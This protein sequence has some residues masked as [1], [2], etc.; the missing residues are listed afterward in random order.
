MTTD[1]G[2]SPADSM[3]LTAQDILS[4]PLITPSHKLDADQ[5]MAEDIDGVTESVFGSGNMN[6]LMLQAGQTD[7]AIRSFGN[8]APVSTDVFSTFVSSESFSR[9]FPLLTD[10]D[11]G[12][13]GGA[14]KS[15]DTD[16]ALDS[17]GDI[18]TADILAP[19]SNTNNASINTA[20]V[21]TLSPSAPAASFSGGGFDG[22]NGTG[23]LPGQD[24]Q[25]P[26]A[27]PPGQNGTNGQNGQNGTNG[28]GHG[29][30]DIDINL[31]DITI[32][33]ENILI[34]LGDTVNVLTTSVTN[35]T[36]LLNNLLCHGNTIDITNVIDLVFDIKHGLLEKIETLLGDVGDKTV[37]IKHLLGDI[38]GDVKNTALDLDLN[39]LDTVTADVHLLLKDALNGQILV[40]GDLTAL[41]SL[42]ADLPALDHLADALGNAGGAVHALQDTLH[43]ALNTVTNLPDT[44]EA[45]VGTL[46]ETLTGLND[47]VCCLLPDLDDAVG[48]LLGGLGI[49]EGGADHDVALDVVTDVIGLPV[50]DVTLDA[51]LNP[52]EDIIGDLDL[53]L[54]GG[55][56][57]LGGS[58]T[59]HGAG[60]T[61]IVL[62]PDIDLIDTDILDGG[63][64]ISL[65][66]IEEITGDIDLDVTT[67]FDLLGDQADGLIDNALGGSE[68]DTPLSELGDTLSGLAATI[69]PDGNDDQDIH[70]DTGSALPDIAFIDTDLDLDIPLDPL[71][72]V[73]GDIDLDLND[74]LDILHSGAPDSPLGEVTEWTETTVGD[75]TGGLF[76][77]IL[78]GGGD[79]LPE[80]V[81]HI[82]EG[83]GALFVEP[84]IQ[85]IGLGRLFG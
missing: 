9:A 59:D 79:T 41:K 46:L 25:S 60:D 11:S 75:I 8:E 77:D 30:K 32:N 78:T 21:T 53:G 57:L 39:V 35:V 45:P 22:D 2:V 51:V 31:G 80:P 33:I 15:V 65:D 76:G 19:N 63:L 5:Y 68:N 42:I 16:R 50:V 74:A 37:L 85:P 44:L 6:F 3:V 27:P 83:L 26:D 66:P 28:N 14:E 7:E 48:G 72:N 29:G 61:D 70:L 23:G 12:R 58:E 47:Q 54:G 62:L 10:T 36:N 69:F 17:R 81:G 1:K 38:L 55:I 13:T 24:G 4:A 43:D 40:G 49:G 64:G 20:S 34:D 82:A 52:V 56:D 73:L 71:E 67:A 84:D 18:D